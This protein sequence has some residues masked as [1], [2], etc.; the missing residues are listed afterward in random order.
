M[1]TRTPSSRGLSLS[2]GKT[3][4]SLGPASKGSPI[5]L[6]AIS[7]ALSALLSSATTALA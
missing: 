2:S 5:L 1:V 3:S 6:G 7:L 4:P